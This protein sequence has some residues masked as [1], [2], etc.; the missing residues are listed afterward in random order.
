MHGT[1]EDVDVSSMVVAAVVERWVTTENGVESGFSEPRELLNNVT[2]AAVVNSVDS[3][4]VDKRLIPYCKTTVS[5]ESTGDLHV[6]DAA[7]TKRSSQQNLRLR[8]YNYQWQ[9]GIQF[10][11]LSLCQSIC[12]SKM[13]DEIFM[14]V[15]S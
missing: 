7:H 15:F 5:L 14:I 6:P 3:V 2:S 13:Q 4:S 9:G 10:T 8:V 12:G 11:R 1:D